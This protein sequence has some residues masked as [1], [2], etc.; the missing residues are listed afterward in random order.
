MQDGQYRHLDDGGFIMVALLVGM[1]VAAV[2]MGAALPAWRQ[3]ALREKETELIFRGEQYARAIV[4]YQKKNDGQYPP[5]IDTLISN[6]YLRKKWKDPVS[7]KDFLPI[8]IGLGTGQAGSPSPG[9]ARGAAPIAPP[10]RSAGPG[11]QGGAGQTPGIIG[12]RS[13]SQA[14]S[15]KIYR[16]Q[17]QHSLW[18]FDAAQLYAKMGYSMNRGGGPGR[19]GPGRGGDQGR[20][21]AG[22]PGRG[23]EGAPAGPGRG[24][25]GPGGP[26]GGAPVGPGRGGRGGL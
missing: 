3:Q 24:G 18:P 14:T 4:L 26:G 17:Q 7:G 8:G 22:G 13:P 19:G 25:R 6:R 23:R 16:Q 10:G 9:G 1:A 11:Q 15:I 20:P 21:G 12:V 5:S 2:W